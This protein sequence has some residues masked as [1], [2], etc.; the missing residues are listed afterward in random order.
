MAVETSSPTLAS[1]RALV[2]QDAARQA[3]AEAQAAEE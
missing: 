3:A 1:Y 2:E